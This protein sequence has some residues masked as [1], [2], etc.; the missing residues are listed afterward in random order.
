M[1]AEGLSAERKALAERYT[2]DAV[3]ARQREKQPAGEEAVHHSLEPSPS[4]IGESPHGPGDTGRTSEKRAAGRPVRP[5]RFS[6]A[7][8]LLASVRGQI[9][10]LVHPVDAPLPNQDDPRDQDDTTQTVSGESD[11]LRCAVCGREGSPD[12]DGWTLQLRAEN[13]LQTVCPGCDDG[14]SGRIHLDG[15]RLAVSPQEAAD[16]LGVT[17]DFFDEYLSGELHVVHRGRRIPI[18]VRELGPG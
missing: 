13:E 12:E 15:E 16:L 9:G 17:R 18:S 2:I 3:E 7:E 6:L 14:A 10:H 1:D 11:R 8:Q 4:A 5:K